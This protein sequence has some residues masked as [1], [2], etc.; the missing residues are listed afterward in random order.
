MLLTHGKRSYGKRNAEKIFCV[1]LLRKWGARG[2]GVWYNELVCFEF[3]FIKKNLF[4]GGELRE[5]AVEIGVSCRQRDEAGEEICLSYVVRGR[6]GL[7][8][9][10]AFLTYEEP[11]S[12][13]LS[14]TRTT[15]FLSDGAVRLVRTGAVSMRLLLRPGD[16]CDGL[17]RT[18]VGT[19]ALRA[20]TKELENGLTGGAGRL[21]ML[22][23]MEAEGLFCH[24]NELEIEVSEVAGVHGH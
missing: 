1:F 12:S 14:G 23:T 2:R 13:G 3:L 18:G 11:E 8:G 9:G 20:R 15:L 22:Y 19:M 24:E 10:A 7:R 6:Y 16:A 5:K 4:F 17:Y 21:R